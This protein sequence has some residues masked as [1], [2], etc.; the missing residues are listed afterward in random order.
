MAI[1]KFGEP[2]RG[3]KR[4][5][6]GISVVS[7]YELHADMDGSVGPEDIEQETVY[8]TPYLCL[9]NFSVFC[10]T[11]AP[12]R[13][14]LP[15]TLSIQVNDG[16]TINFQSPRFSSVNRYSPLGEWMA[17]S[18]Q[19]SD[20]DG[21]SRIE[22]PGDGDLFTI[23]V[24]ITGANGSVIR[25]NETA[26]GP[27]PNGIGEVYH[28]EEETEILETGKLY[29]VFCTHTVQA[30]SNYS[31]RIVI[32]WQPNNCTVDGREYYPV[33]LTEEAYTDYATMAADAGAPFNTFDLAVK[34]IER[35]P[36]S[37]EFTSDARIILNL[38]YLSADFHN[39]IKITECV[40]TMPMIPGEGV[41]E[42]L[43]PEVDM[44]QCSM[45]AT[46]STYII[47]GK[48]V[49]GRVTLTFTVGG[50]FKYGDSISSASTYTRVARAYAP[51]TVYTLH[52]E[53]VTAG[54]TQT[55]TEYLSVVGSKWGRSPYTEDAY[56]DYQV[57]WYHPPILNSISVERYRD[58]AFHI[59]DD[60]GGYCLVTYSIS[61]ASLDGMNTA[62]KAT[63]SYDLPT[64][65]ATRTVAFAE[66][67]INTTLG[68]QADPSRVMDI[69]IRLY[70]KYNT[71]GI[72][73]RTIRL[74]K[75]GV[76]MEFMHDGLGVA[77]GKNA[78][79]AHT[80][81]IN[82][83]WTLYIGTAYIE[84]YSDNTPKLLAKWMR[85]ADAQQTTVAAM[86]RYQ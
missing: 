23:H 27:R 42:A 40:K 76:I 20:P 34:N 36:V 66:N 17:Y 49:H 16:E 62:M 59:Q 69:T 4:T 73:G 5:F 7:C 52:G 44:T 18:I 8:E 78:T 55:R 54:E 22:I 29:H 11:K 81:D 39:G 19:L 82:R 47:N 86:A 80:F 38:Y 25:F 26:C 31:N 15:F 32:S 71:N 28:D 12:L 57:L 14:M 72:I 65:N 60:F 50:I 53:E 56:L 45:T 41:D 33:R 74:P 35:L 63:F 48:Y 83:D 64:G 1:M 24:T 84:N 79:E 6:N 9:S 43:L 21:E 3:I 10:N 51:G 37:T 2:W 30:G 58:S 75:A 61:F 85:D 68:I 67:E 46:P 13:A 70:D 77:V